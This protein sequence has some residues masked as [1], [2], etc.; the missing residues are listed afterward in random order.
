MRERQTY[1]TRP[2][3]T[4]N[5]SR[6]PKIGSPLTHNEKHVLNLNYY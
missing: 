3:F 6:N 5:E 2:H 4:L 1:L